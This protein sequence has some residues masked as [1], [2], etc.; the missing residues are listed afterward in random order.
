MKSHLIVNHATS[1]IINS[2]KEHDKPRLLIVLALPVLIF[3]S[4]CASANRDY[5]E[6]KY[7]DATY[8]SLNVPQKPYDVTINVAF[9]TNGKPNPRINALLHDQ[10]VKVLNT[11]HLMT[12]AT[13]PG[14]S[15]VGKLDITVNN[16]GNMAGAVA[17]GFVSGLTLGA[18]G[19][20]IVDNYEMT[21]TYTAPNGSAI[22]K[23]YHHALHSMSG[24][25]HPP[26]KDLIPIP[27]GKP[28][29][30]VIIEDML[31]NFLRDLQRERRLAQLHK[32]PNAPNRSLI[33]RSLAAPLRAEG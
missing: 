4:G 19:P 25:V 2:P 5:V 18:V 22:T 9:Q 31:L 10:V 14:A 3:C 33:E 6:P 17:Q 27:S 24:L 12:E 15:R 8:G 11:S 13:S 16:F 1:P 26:A 29:F 7:R 30:E 20:E 32:L 28:S 21:A 23:T